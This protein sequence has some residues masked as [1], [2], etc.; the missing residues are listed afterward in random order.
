M[1]LTTV[2]NIMREIRALQRAFVD[3]E[4]WNKNIKEMLIRYDITRDEFEDINRMC[5]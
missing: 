3:T 5:R 1:T 2:S 4:N